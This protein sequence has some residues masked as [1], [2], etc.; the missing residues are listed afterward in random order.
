MGSVKLCA[1]ENT[2]ISSK[3]PIENYGGSR[4]VYAGM[5][6]SNAVYRTLLYFDLSTIPGDVQIESAVLRMY[7]VQDRTSAGQFTACMI[8]SSWDPDNVT[9]NSQPPIQPPV[10]GNTVKISASGWYS[11]NITSMVQL[12][13]AD[14]QR[15]YGL[16]I[17]SRE[18]E[19]NFDTHQFHSAQTYFYKE[20]KPVL[21]IEYRHKN[22]VVLSA[23]DT[24]NIIETIY[25]CERNKYS[26]WQNTSV[27]SLY[28][29]FVQNRGQYPACI[30]VQISPDKAAA[31]DEAAEY[32][33]NP[34]NVQAIVPQRFGFYT[35]LACK[36]SLYN[37]NTKLKVWFQAQ[38]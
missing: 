10:S 37:R 33:V 30:R 31:F 14:R 35:R 25:A 3:N 13:L 19:E 8:E 1:S 4:A 15:N 26:A 28:T 6:S 16:M 9:W 17:I 21:E 34:G 29:F 23:R 11:W 27:Y 18:D 12:W 24:A 20:Y 32:L 7:S 5:D 36:A 2:Y 38:M 22:A